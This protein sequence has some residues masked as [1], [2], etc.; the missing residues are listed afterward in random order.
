MEHSKA[1]CTGR[2]EHA[3]ALYGLSTESGVCRRGHGLLA[4]FGLDGQSSDAPAMPIPEHHRHC[5]S[6]LR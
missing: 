3:Q 5:E 4:L 1:S 6:L 2:A